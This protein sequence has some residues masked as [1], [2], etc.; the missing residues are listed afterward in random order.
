[1]PRLRGGLVAILAIGAVLPSGCVSDLAVDVVDGEVLT[2]GI[3]QEEPYGYP[4][5]DG[6]AKGFSP[7]IA[8]LVLDRLGY[9]EPEFEVVEFGR[10]ADGLQSHRFDMVAA[11]MYILPARMAQI[12]FSDPVYCVYESLA[13]PE[14]NPDRVTDHASLAGTDLIVAL[15]EGTAQ[16][17]YLRDAG[18]PEERIRVFEDIQAMYPALHDGEVDVVT[19][20]GPTVDAQVANRDGMEAVARFLPK[21]AAGSEVYPCGA[22]SFR[23]D[24]TAFRDAFND[25]LDQLRADG[26]TSRII[27]GYEGF[28]QSDVDLANALTVADFEQD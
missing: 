25:E 8:R 23:L 28:T 2:I 12:Q 22:F 15:A 17:G 6:E 9:P 7:D 26:T 24:D 21:D 1:M 3:A 19:G 20:T 27:T 13:V 4:D 16:E 10:L 18:V 5:S 11:G 14:G